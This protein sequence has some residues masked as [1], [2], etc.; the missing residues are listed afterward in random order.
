MHPILFSFGGITVFSYGFIVALAFVAAFSYL[1]HSL[2]KSKERMFLQDELYSLV[3][4]MIVFGVIGSR[5][6]FILINLREFMSAPLD[7]FKIW[8]GGL[9]YYGGLFAALV[10]ITM[11]AKEKKIQIFELVD[12]FVPALALGHA[13]G[14]I[15]CFFAGCCYGRES[16]LPWSVVFEDKH[17]LAVVGAH[18][19]PTQIY[20]AL[21]NFALFMF[22]HFYSKKEHK[23]GAVLALYFMCYAVLRFIVEFFRGDY[24]GIQY[25]GLSISQATSIFLFI[26]GV[27]I[28]AR[29]RK[30][31]IQK[32]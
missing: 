2:S 23:T 31:R 24:R 4:R 14:R 22:L 21:G 11:Y 6:L 28:Y 17:S 20:E 25:F 27:C 1:S 19:H 5:F 3:A 8:K 30:N 16:N 13:I 26:T 12:F 29:T 7:I 10:F 32:V 9:V 15:G 18:L